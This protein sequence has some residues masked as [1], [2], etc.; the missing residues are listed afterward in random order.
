MKLT[1][2]GLGLQSSEGR[3]LHMPGCHPSER[4]QA[5]LQGHA[6]CSPKGPRG[7][8]FVRADLT[9]DMNSLDQEWK[10]RTLDALAEQQIDQFFLTTPS[11][12]LWGFP[13]SLLTAWF[14]LHMECCWEP[15]PGGKPG[16]CPDSSRSSCAMLWSNGL[17]SLALALLGLEGDGENE[18]RK[19]C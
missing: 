11:C 7:P 4:S 8:G 15:S 16:F 18:I 19:W 6:P 12:W 3:L 13:S 2:P 1:S 9:R 14:L 17:H 10:S 5:C